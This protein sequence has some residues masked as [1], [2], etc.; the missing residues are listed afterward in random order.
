MFN[1]ISVWHCFCRT[2]WQFQVFP[3]LA[4]VTSFPALCLAPVTSFPALAN[5]CTNAHPVLS[6]FSHPSVNTACKFS[7]ISHQLRDFF[8]TIS[9]FSIRLFLSCLL[10]R[11]NS[12][13]SLILRYLRKLV[14]NTSLV[15]TSS[16]RMTIVS[17]SE[18]S[19]KIMCAVLRQSIDRK[20]W[21]ENRNR[22]SPFPY[23]KQNW[24]RSITI[25]LR[26]T[27]YSVSDT[28][29]LRKKEIRVLLSG[30]EPKT[31]RL[32]VRMLYHWAT[33]DSWELRPY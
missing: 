6:P 33:G 15:L 7:R 21:K 14:L 27:Y 31:S 26:I 2:W 28:G 10:H 23:S 5:G 12:L 13:I 4:P 32:L 18:N 16:W 20:L 3:R 11:H 8:A 9:N 30:V 17:V 1:S 22:K 29:I 25:I 19:V 24:V